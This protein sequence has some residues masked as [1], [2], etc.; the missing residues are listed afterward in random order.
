[1]SEERFRGIADL[2]PFPIAIIDPGGHYLYIN[3]QFTEVFG[4]TLSDLPT[5]K[6]WFEAAFPDPTLRNDAITAWRADLSSS[7]IG[8]ARPRTFPVRCKDGTT[9]EILFRPVTLADHNEYITYEDIT[10]QKDAENAILAANQR[11]QDIIEFL[12]DP[13]FVIDTHK[14]VIAWN[15]AMED[16]TG[17]PR[18]DMIGKGDYEYSLP[19][20]GERRPILIDIVDHN[21]P[22]IE[23]NYRSVWREGNS[24]TAEG[25]IPK[26]RGGKGLYL[27]GKASLLYN[28][29]GERAGAIQSIR[30]L[31]QRK[32]MEDK[33]RKSTG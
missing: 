24:I 28:P 10:E 23:A 33:I 8:I 16:L 6:A 18:E 12:P 21:D 9:R 30:D 22:G 5:G 4:Y 19:F 29:K 14:R 26:F 27:Q 25:F 2:S 31:T 7:E 17:I 32:E 13:T 11:M 3:H 15:R 20:Y 1:M